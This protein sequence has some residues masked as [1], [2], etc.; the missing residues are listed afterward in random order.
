MADGGTGW[1]FILCRHGV[2]QKRG[3]KY[4][5]GVSAGQVG[6][7]PVS[8]MSPLVEACLWFYVR[9]I[10][11]SCFINQHVFLIHYRSFWLPT[12]GDRGDM[13]T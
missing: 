6:I 5:S 10:V 11:S 9:V 3:P 8:P 7:V 4:L 12:S 2:L 1:I 13:G